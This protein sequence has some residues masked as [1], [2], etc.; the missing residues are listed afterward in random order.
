MRLYHFQYF[1]FDGVQF[2]RTV[3]PETTK[4][5]ALIAMMLRYKF[6]KVVVLGST[7]STW[8]QTALELTMQLKAAGIEVQKPAAFAVGNFETGML[9]KIK[10][11]GKLYPKGP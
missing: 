5:P 10:S 9:R 7:D 4:G 1:H 11:S 2:S 3:A 6:K 8:F